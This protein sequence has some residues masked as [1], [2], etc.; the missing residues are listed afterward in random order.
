M[1]VTGASGVV[2][3]ELMERA[4]RRGWDAVGCSAGGG[5][6]SVAWPMGDTAPPP[7]LRRPWSV[8]VHA[9]ARPRFDLPP[10]TAR[11]ANVRPLTALAPLMSSQTHLIHISTAYATG[12]TGSIESTDLA[13]YRNTYEYS[14]AEA[15]RVARS[16]YAPLTIVRPSIVVGR[17]SDGAVA[18]LSGPYILPRVFAAGLVTD[19][20][21]DASAFIDLVPVCDVAECVLDIA[22]TPPPPDVR[23]ETI[24][25]G[26]NAPRLEEVVTLVTGAANR[27][28]AER[29][30]PALPRFEIVPVQERHRTSVLAPLLPYLTITRPLPI[31]RHIEPV[32]PLV[33]TLVRWVL[34][35]DPELARQHRAGVTPRGEST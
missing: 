24:G 10:E 21:G 9:A 15:E 18:R 4:R 2:G 33:E 28:L 3:A 17:R 34:E 35:N 20:A 11:R 6:A 27:W 31:T 30:A 7:A 22:G 1:L 12:W 13:D 14:K 26:V 19:I 29:S 8:I 32:T 16:R 25:L 23:V 5:N